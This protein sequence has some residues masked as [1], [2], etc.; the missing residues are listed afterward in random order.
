MPFFKS[1]LLSITCQ[2]LYMY[3]LITF[4]QNIYEVGFMMNF[5]RG[6]NWDLDLPKDTQILQGKMGAEPDPPHPWA[7]AFTHC[8]LSSIHDYYLLYRMK[9]YHFKY[10]NHT[11]AITLDVSLNLLISASLSVKWNWTKNNVLSTLKKI[12]PLKFNKKNLPLYICSK[13]TVFKK[14]LRERIKL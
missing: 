9:Y 5:H 2:A 7:C 8:A 3:Y 12:L 14:M 10:K 1:Y 4:S 11:P 6:E 13:L